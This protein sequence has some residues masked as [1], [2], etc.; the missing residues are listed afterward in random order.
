MVLRHL[1]ISLLLSESESLEPQDG[2]E[3]E[4]SHMTSLA[5]KKSDQ[6]RVLIALRRTAVASTISCYIGKDVY[7][8]VYIDINVYLY[9]WL[10]IYVYACLDM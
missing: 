2:R 7:E 9:I 5:M 10:C 4:P 3:R 6:V 1:V 8:Y